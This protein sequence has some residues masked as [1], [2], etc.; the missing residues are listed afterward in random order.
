VSAHPAAQTSPALSDDVSNGFREA[1]RRLAASVMI[2][3]SRDTDGTPHGM[4]ASSVIS[5]SMEPASMLI[6]VNRTAGIHPVLLRSKVF[7]INL[8]SDEQSDLL[9]PF[10]TTALRDQRFKSDCWSDAWTTD[11]G[12]LPWLPEAS[13]SIECAVDLVTDYGTHSLFIG[14]VQQVHCASASVKSQAITR[15]L[16]WLAGQQASLSLQ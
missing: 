10:S 9:K 2:I 6:A 13:A 1:M 16:V 3:S 4:V 8:L 5:V 12:R 11:S 15:P 14:R 7:C